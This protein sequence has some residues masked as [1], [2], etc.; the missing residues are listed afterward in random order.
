MPTPS[1]IGISVVFVALFYASRLTYQEQLRQLE[2]ETRA[3]TAVF[4]AYLDSNL[5]AADAVA[6]TATRHPAVRQ[7]HPR[8]AVD[9]LQPLARGTLLRGEPSVLAGIAGRVTAMG[10]PAEVFW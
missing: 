8:A 7:L 10:I 6:L 3:M 1:S 2:D 9:V 5:A 4:V